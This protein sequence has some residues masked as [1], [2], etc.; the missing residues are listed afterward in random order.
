MSLADEVSKKIDGHNTY[1]TGLKKLSLAGLFLFVFFAWLGTAGSYLGFFLLTVVFVASVPLFWQRFRQDKVLVLSALFIVYLA[2]RTLWAVYEFPE[3]TPAHI[4]DALEWLYLWLFVPLAWSL[5]LFQHKYRTALL[6]L[7]VGFALAVIRHTNWQA[8]DV[9]AGVSRCGFGFQSILGALLL[10]CCLLGLLVFAP[11]LIGEKRS[12]W[13]F[14]VRLMLWLAV[15]AVVAE[16]VILTQTRIV[17]LAFVVVVPPLFLLRYRNEIVALWRNGRVVALIVVVLVVALLFGVVKSNEAIF[18]ERVAQFKDDTFAL[19]MLQFDEIEADN[20]SFAIRVAM[21]QQGFLR[22]LERP[23]IGWGSGGIPRDQFFSAETDLTRHTPHFHNT[24]LEFML[25]FG[26]VGGV[27]FLL[28]VWQLF[29]GLRTARRQHKVD[30]DIYFFLIGMSL[31]FA[32]WCL[33]DFQLSSTN[34]RFFF[35]VVFGFVYAI[36]IADQ[37][38]PEQAALPQAVYK[39]K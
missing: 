38:E 5:K 23:W 25:R 35:C 8:C 32:V 24:Y 1:V 11:R 13:L 20:P 39:Q 18:D 22:W 4:N 14:A 26:L 17:W 34:W 9:L 33:A 36:I 16:F 3:N 30:K 29:S 27:I 2:G 19:M 21:N 6:V 28:L 10:A 37:T 15:V 31:L 12:G 7:G